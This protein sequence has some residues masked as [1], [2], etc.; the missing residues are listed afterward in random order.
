MGF[1]M[2]LSYASTLLANS[3]GFGDLAASLATVNMQG[4]VRLIFSARDGNVLASQSLGAAPLPA[5]QGDV[6]YSVQIGP[7]FAYQ[8]TANLPRIFNLSAFNTPLV[9]NT[10]SANGTPSW[11]QTVTTPTAASIMDASA[12]QVLEFASGDWLAVAQRSSPGL[13]LFQ[14]P[15]AGSLSAPITIADTP[16]T[17]TTNVSDTATI[18]RGADQ[19]LLTIS[20]QENGISSYRITPSGGVEWVDSYGAVNGLAV[21]GLSMM[22]TAQIG[23]VDFVVLAA[24]NSSSL[25]VLRVNAMGVFFETD[26]VIDTLSTRFS[27]IAAFDGFVV[28]GRMIFAAAG[29]DAGLTLFE[30]LP[31][32]QLSHLQTF[33]LEGGVG[34]QAVTA[35]NTTVLGS[36]VAIHMVDAGADQIFRFDLDLGNLGGRITASGGSATGSAADDRIWGSASADVLLAGGGDDFLNDGLGSDTLTGGAGADVFVF[37]RDGAV[38]HITDFQDGVDRIDVSSWGRIYSTA[39]LTITTTSA[40][41]EAVYG[42]ERLTIAAYSGGALPGGALTDADFIF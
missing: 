1:D 15:D 21:N 5:A 6:V 26:H 17:Y 7:D 22:Q 3:F 37:A 9:V 31:D 10:L 41:T 28:Q 4:T 11:A 16:K 42:S 27:H 14:L 12:L 2:Q 40:G 29:T 18:T 30:L 36:T 23:G 32:G 25:T 8:N 38:D 20:A 34:L 39:S 13:T 19:I 35:L 33:V 24:T